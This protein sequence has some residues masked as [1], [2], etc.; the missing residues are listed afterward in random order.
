[1]K[2]RGALLALL[3]ATAVGQAS[4]WPGW[5]GPTG[6]GISDE[7]DLPLRWDAKSGGNVLW[8][9]PLPGQDEKNRQ[10]QNQS[11]PIVSR[12][13]V[14]VTASYWGAGATDKDFPE[15]HVACY[16]ADDGKLL[17]DVTVPPGPWRLRDLRGGYTA[18]T[19]AADGERV[20][21]LFGSAVLAALDFDG[22][23]LWRKEIVPH[24]FDVAIGISPVLYKDYIL[25]QGDQVG[26]SSR[27]MAFDRKSGALAWERKRPEAGFC[28]STPVLAKVGERTQ[29]LTA[30]SGG[31]QGVD[32]DN[33]T[34]LWWC[35]G[36]GDTVSPVY[37]EGLVYC[38]TG[39]NSPGIAVEP[40][41]SGDVTST[42]RKWRNER[43]PGGFGSPVVVDGL[44][45][46]VCD[47]GVLKC[48]RM[49]DGTE[50]ASVRLAGAEPAASPLVTADGLVYA[51]S[52]GRS[53]V[54]KPGPKPEVL[55]TGDL[56]DPSQAS[57]A[58][59]GGR[60]FLKGRKYL[61]CVGTK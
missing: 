61:W 24:D 22:K 10:D 46:K 53:Y 13:R 27:W 55:G 40:T 30:F 48:W 44:L 54:L 14:F 23:L 36:A 21:V 26:R 19:P 45:Y 33:G 28:H 38:D 60:L 39:R 59:A 49:K 51:A 11:S 34:V 52:A 35:S 8:K 7:R 37:A 31:L 16:R 29:L 58:A 9:A 3:M 5:R 43:M 47:G 17:W 41:G 32:P 1:M 20:Y 56:G 42:L 2:T 57:P 50:V 15:H 6:Q 25:L 12:G 4:D 18:P